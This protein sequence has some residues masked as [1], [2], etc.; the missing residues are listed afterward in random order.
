MFCIYKMYLTSAK[1]YKNA[2]VDLSRV[3]KTEEIW[4]KMKNMQDGLSV[5]NIS[6]LVLKVIFSIYKTKNLTKE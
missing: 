5:Q 4:T 3:K 1:G 6:D 2:G